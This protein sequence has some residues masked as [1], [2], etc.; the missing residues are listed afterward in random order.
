M[1][2]KGMI[3][4]N[5][6]N[7]SKNLLFLILSIMD[8]YLNILFICIRKT[9]FRKRNIKKSLFREKIFLGWIRRLRKCKGKKSREIFKD[10]RRIYLKI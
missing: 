10:K 7:G 4:I 1:K 9:I 3:I 2:P 5:L 8:L 6:R